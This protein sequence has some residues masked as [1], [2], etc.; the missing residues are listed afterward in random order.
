MGFLLLGSHLPN[1]HLTFW[2]IHIPIPNISESKQTLR[3][4]IQ[5]QTNIMVKQTKQ[6]LN[7]IFINVFIINFR[8][9]PFKYMVTSNKSKTRSIIR[10]CLLFLKSNTDKFAL[11]RPNLSSKFPI[12]KQTKIFLSE[13]ASHRR[14][15]IVHNSFHRT[16]RELGEI[17]AQK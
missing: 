12:L 3:G 5:F 7:N 9:H 17:L 13:N 2:N 10:L 11:A 1:Q 6:D 4:G 16:R 14:N 8:S 15:H